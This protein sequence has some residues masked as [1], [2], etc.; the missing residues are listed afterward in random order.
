MEKLIDS[1]KRLGIFV[2]YDR[3][4]I[5]N[6]YVVFLLNSILEVANS[7]IIV[8]NGMIEKESLK[9]LQYFT[10]H[11]YIRENIGYDG[12]AYKDVFLKFLSKDDMGKWDEFILFNDTFYG[13]FF[14]WKYIFEVFQ[15][16][17]VDFWGLSKWIKASSTLLDCEIEEHVQAYFIVI[18]RKMIVSPFFLKFWKDMNTPITYKDAILDFEVK[19]SAFFKKR[20]FQYKTWIDLVN[21][22]YLLREN[23]VVYLKH[24]DSLI[25]E[26]H[27]P[28]VKRK[29]FSITNFIQSSKIMKYIDINYGFDNSMIWK[30]LKYLDQCCNFKPFSFSKIEE[31]YNN[32]K[33]KYI[34]GY[35]KWGKEIERYF[36][37]NNWEIAGFVVSEKESNN[38]KLINYCDLKLDACDG[39]VLA[40]GQ[41]AFKEV[42]P[43]VICHY[44]ENQLL[45]PE[46]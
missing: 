45:L 46:F 33:K 20:G 5:V 27:F 37:Y 19:F 44:K 7:I 2:F 1:T 26:L 11:I 9:K 30:H 13:P 16:E 28:V 40:L 34:Y 42:Y 41:K 31:F 15:K 35:G 4:G 24:A 23:E 39:M 10:H 6:D 18:R 3:N 8:V 36:E 38:E 12:G 25:C 14:S 21:G 17:N 32:H 22:N 29:V 43:I